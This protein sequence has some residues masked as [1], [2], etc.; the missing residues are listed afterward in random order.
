MN[1]ELPPEDADISVESVA[2]PLSTRRLI[3]ADLRIVEPMQMEAS[4]QYRLMVKGTGQE[5]IYPKRY[6]IESYFIFPAQ[7]RISPS[8]YPIESFYRD[9][10]SYIN[11]RIPKLSFKEIMGYTENIERSPLKKMRDELLSPTRKNGEKLLFLQQ[12]GRVFACSFHTFIN[13]KIRRFTRQIDRIKRLRSA[14]SAEQDVADRQAE[15]IFYEN[16]RKIMEVFREWQKLLQLSQGLGPEILQQMRAVD[17]YLVHNLHD[18]IL[19]VERQ[20][21]DVR[22]PKHAGENWRQQ[23]KV[24]LRCLRIYSKLQKYQW[25]DDQSG[26]LDLERYFFHRGTL[27]R[28]MWSA[29]YLDTRTKQLF[30]FQQ[31]VG[32]MLAAGFAGLWAVSAD[33][34]IRLNTGQWGLSSSSLGASTFLLITALTMAYI[35]KDRIKE[36]GRGYLK[37]GLIG[38]MPD[39]SSKILYQS[40]GS[41]EPLH[42]GYHE[43][44]VSYIDPNKI[45]ED[46]QA[47]MKKVPNERWEQEPHTIICYRKRV[48]L[49]GKRIRHLKRKIRAIYTFYR[50]NVSNF[51]AP[52]DLPYEE[53]LVPTRQLQATSRLFPK[54][55][56]IDL[57]LRLK[58]TVGAKE[59]DTLYQYWRLV[60]NKAGLKRIDLIPLGEAEEQA[61]LDY[62]SIEEDPLSSMDTLASPRPLR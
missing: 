2:S 53:L 35:M 59:E 57:I 16:F 12:E 9:L 5:V 32:A 46:V 54:V 50:L 52:L 14:S 51:L 4:F 58:A 44:K 27:K 20:F 24:A 6:Q 10:K 28:Q 11:F 17:E 21:Y 38:D 29:L 8:S 22:V 31:Q 55:Y 48:D 30:K 19:Q 15:A 49:Q 37:G 7:M 25:V 43:E 1:P 62:D 33:F 39:N 42:V 61:S 40:S 60:I 13:R 56:H 3:K 23:I 34:I 41:G 45:P 26:E 18:Y 47:L 36:L